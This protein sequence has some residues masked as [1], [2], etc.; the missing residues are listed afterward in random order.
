MGSTDLIEKYIDTFH[1][2]CIVQ[3][4]IYLWAKSAKDAIQYS[5]AKMEFAWVINVNTQPA[6]DKSGLSNLYINWINLA[7]E[8]LKSCQLSIMQWLQ[9]HVLS[10]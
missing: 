2:T 8:V 9:P 7:V 1:T 6:P 4:Y 10:V 5:N 3:W